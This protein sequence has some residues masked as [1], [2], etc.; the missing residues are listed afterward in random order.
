MLV[1]DMS[2]H[3]L[4]AAQACR[5]AG[6][7]QRACR[8]FD[9]NAVVGREPAVR[10]ACRPAGPAQRSCQCFDLNAVVGH[11]LSWESVVATA[12][13][14]LATQRSCMPMHQ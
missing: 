1:L 4:Q 8:C 6:P 3:L 12:F 14:L 10:I 13:V 5:P 7:V 11:F 9:V 2:V